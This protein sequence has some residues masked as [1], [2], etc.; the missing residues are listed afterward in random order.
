MRSNTGSRIQSSRESKANAALSKA[1]SELLDLERQQREASTPAAPAA[2]AGLPDPASTEMKERLAHFTPEE[3]EQLRAAAQELRTARGE[4]P[5]GAWRAVIESA[6][7]DR[8]SGTGRYARRPA[9]TGPGNV[10]VGGTDADRAAARPRLEING[11]RESD[12]AYAVRT[13]PSR[14]AAQRMLNG[15]SLAGL[16]AIAR[17]EDIVPSGTKADLLVRLMRVLYDRHADAAAITRMVN[18]ST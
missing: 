2:P 18:R 9:G 13:A 5:A 3:R 8:L 11:R 17:E 14:D 6:E 16:R 4:T 10:P 15:Y 7:Q 12:R 1:R